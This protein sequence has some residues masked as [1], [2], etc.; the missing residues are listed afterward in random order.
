MSWD[1]WRILTIVSLAGFVG[2][3]FDQMVLFMFIASFLY[4]LWL[5]RTWFQFRDWLM[6]PNRNRPLKYEWVMNNVTK[7]IERV[8]LKNKSQKKKLREYL[9]LFQSATSSLPDAII[10]LGKDGKVDWANTAATELLGIRWPQ[11][12]HIR[13]NNLIRDPKFQ[14]LINEPVKKG[15]SIIV[16]SPRNQSKQLEMTIVKYLKDGRL[17]IVRDVT[18]TVKLQ[19]MRRDFVA[20]VSHELR[21]P[22]TV[23]HGYLET[24]DIDS[25]KEQWQTA[26]P[27]MKQQ[28][29]RM[30]AMVT[31]LL[32][33]SKLEM[34]DKEVVYEPVHIARL[35]NAIAEDAM[36]LAEFDNHIIQ[37]NILSQCNVLADE[38]ELRTAISNL[39]FNA[40][41]YTPSTKD[42]II[43]WSVDKFG[44]HLK[45][46]DKGEG[47]EEHHLGRL[48]ERFYRVDKGR[49]EQQAGGTGLG[50]AIVK[51]VLQR[52]HAELIITS[53]LGVGSCFE[54][55]FAKKNIIE[56]SENIS[57]VK[58]H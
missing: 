27:A 37:V 58:E 20:N 38:N 49:S 54:C 28:T 30:N 42:I 51:H 25:P 40:V 55:R 22:L 48:T 52:Q 10:V 41:K 46:I 53:E 11:D 36:R 32:A 2:L 57:K 16:A 1:Y 45:V 43:Q 5:Q 23:L 26:L 18:K 8:R 4:A 33:L 21:T 9:N 17:L 31:D 12:S 47:I 7:K 34:G 6:K 39:V 19:E 50:L 35:L 29:Q 56:N 24:L 44:G 13:L 3:L 14:Q 15:R